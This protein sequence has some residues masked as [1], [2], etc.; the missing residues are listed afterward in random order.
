MQASRYAR[1]VGTVQHCGGHHFQ[2][3]V[4][5]HRPVRVR[6]KRVIQRFDGAEAVVRRILYKTNPLHLKRKEKVMG[7]RGS[8]W[9]V[10][11]LSES[12]SER[13]SVLSFFIRNYCVK[14]TSKCA[15]GMES[16]RARARERARARFTC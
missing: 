12:V 9:V 11:W 3:V 8:G 2:R 10:E 16:L 5:A 4:V 6:N 13:V 14:T 15:R 1:H 7:A